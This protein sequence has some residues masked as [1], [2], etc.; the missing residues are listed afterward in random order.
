MSYTTQT[1]KPIGNKT[2]AN[3][4]IKRA[5]EALAADAGSTTPLLNYIAKEV[6]RFAADVKATA[7]RLSALTNVLKIKGHDVTGLLTFTPVAEE[8]KPKKER[9][10]KEKP[11]KTEAPAAATGE[12]AAEAPKQD[13]A[14]TGAT[15]QPEQQAPAAAEVN[16]LVA[17]M[18]TSGLPDSVI[19][20]ELAGALND[21]QSVPSTEA[22][23]KRI[24]ELQA[25]VASLG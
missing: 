12:A 23:V 10:K 7:R 1:G 4:I 17:Q 18:R 24:A 15:P 21:L 20:T 22:T 16:P 8:P 2:A 6:D 19:K 13:P 5:K 11:A 25:A 9:A 14:P 3:L